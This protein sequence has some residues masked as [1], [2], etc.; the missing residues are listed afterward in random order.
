MHARGTRV[1]LSQKTAPQVVA[2]QGGDIS[3]ISTVEARVVRLLKGAPS[4][5]VLSAV[6]LTI[7]SRDRD[8]KA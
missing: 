4:S 2:G 8:A 7:S 5:L 1:V 6:P 3:V